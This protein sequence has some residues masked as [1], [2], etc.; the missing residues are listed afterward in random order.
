MS[1]V[2]LSGAGSIGVTLVAVLL[3]ALQV[4]ASRPEGRVPLPSVQNAV[5]ASES[6]QQVRDEGRPN[7]VR[8]P[9]PPAAR[10]VSAME[11][12]PAEFETQSAVKREALKPAAQSAAVRT[13]ST[14]TFAPLRPEP[15]L[16][17]YP[18][19]AI[20]SVA[21]AAP[22]MLKPAPAQDAKPTPIKPLRPQQMSKDP[23]QLG[24]AE[25]VPQVAKPSQH[26]ENLADENSAHKPPGA[27][28]GTVMLDGEGVHQGR[29]LLRILE[30][31]EGPSVEIGWPANGT[32]REHLFQRFASCY[33]MRIALMDG[34]GRLF[35][36]DGRRQIPWPVNLDRYS[37][38]VRQANGVVG[39]AERQA[40][41][42]IR[43]H[44]GTVTGATVVR[45][46]PRR[47]DAILLGG[48]HAL[49]GGDYA[50]AKTI[51]AT[52]QLNGGSV[53]VD[54]V[55]VD[56]RRVPGGIDLSLGAGRTCGA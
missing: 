15:D 55:I 24:P 23:E 4:A 44:H 2:R 51:R 38:Y 11:G 45:L 50:R 29:A 39:R 8:L 43:A 41:G 40:V 48:L 36:A 32:V 26:A 10:P 6:P 22:K 20:P 46:F 18:P 35:V 17:A 19:D 31:G 47:V 37:G 14:K 42:R 25:A 33:G 5:S 21:P 52:Y 12:A 27:K 49:I 9:P 28:N 53:I 16:E 7:T 1:D 13:P 30:H 34:D 3:L 56:G 54:A